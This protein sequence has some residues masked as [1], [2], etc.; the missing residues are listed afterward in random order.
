MV[1]SPN[2]REAQDIK[3]L[4]KGTEQHSLKGD[5]EVLNIVTVT[6]SGHQ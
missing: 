3:A 2:V 6:R 5:G 4:V 1:A